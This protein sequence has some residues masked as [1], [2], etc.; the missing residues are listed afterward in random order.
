MTK[1]DVQVRPFADFIRE[2]NRG[3]THDELSEYLQQLTAAVS[4]T[5]KKGRLVLTIEVAPMGD[6]FQVSDKITLK[7]PEHNRGASTYFATADHNLVRTDP[8]QLQFE[9]L[10]EVPPPPG[11]DLATGEVTDTKESTA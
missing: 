3:T 4:D 11:V 5:G 10:A 7:L 9:S 2:T 8:R 6:A 1:P